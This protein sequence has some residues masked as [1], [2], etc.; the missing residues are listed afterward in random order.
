MCGRFA[1]CFDVQ[2][3]ADWLAAE[4]PAEP[5]TPSYNIAPGRAVLACRLGAAGRREL[6]PFHWGLIP[7]WAKDRKLGYKTFNARAE[8]VAEKPSFRAAFRRRRC[9]IPADAF[10]EWQSTPDG[11]QPF[12]FRHRD[13]RPMTFAGLWEHWVDPDSRETLE[14]ATIIVTSA[15]QTV[16]A[17]HDRMPVILDARHWDAWLDPAE[18]AL[19]ELT[20]LLAP[21]PADRLIRYPVAKAVGNPR[22][23]GPECLAPEGPQ[24]D[25]ESPSKGPTD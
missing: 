8:T 13:Q 2:A 5:T 21:Y 11:K 17:I 6:S 4:P 14:S 23:D 7:G 19:S 25:S 3:T 22:C 18:R 20:A 9:L 1:Q 15:N 10:Y 16:A 24:T 12:A